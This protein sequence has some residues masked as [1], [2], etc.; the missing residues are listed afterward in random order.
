MSIKS[1]SFSQQ[2]ES[3]FSHER[4]NLDLLL[5]KGLVSEVVE[6]VDEVRKSHVP[7]QV[8]HD[9]VRHVIPGRVRDHV[10]ILKPLAGYFLSPNQELVVVEAKESF[11]AF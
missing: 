5:R 6:V 3:G 9:V 7:V 2:K 10:A 4:A 11:E 1:V 8:V